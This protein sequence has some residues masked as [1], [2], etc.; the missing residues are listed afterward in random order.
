MPGM[1]RNKGSSFHIYEKG[2]MISLCTLSYSILCDNYHGVDRD[3]IP[4]LLRCTC[5]ATVEAVRGDLNR[6]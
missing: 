5:N 6:D 2:M 4:M 3:V 1:F